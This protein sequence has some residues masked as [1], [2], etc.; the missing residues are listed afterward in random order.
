[1]KRLRCEKTN[2]QLDSMILGLHIL[3][4]GMGEGGT[5]FFFNFSISCK[6]KI[7]SA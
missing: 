2:A 4:K 7:L 6:L 5:T 1:M 3:R